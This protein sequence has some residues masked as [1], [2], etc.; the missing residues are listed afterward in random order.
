MTNSMGTE[1]WSKVA[2]VLRKL[3]ARVD[4]IAVSSL[5]RAETMERVP[6]IEMCLPITGVVAPACKQSDK[7]QKN[8]MRRAGK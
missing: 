4:E 1:V 2:A 8:A 3:R 5:E 6:Y 7:T